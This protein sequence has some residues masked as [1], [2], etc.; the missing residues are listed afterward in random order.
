MQLSSQRSA[1]VFDIMC[2][3]SATDV[4]LTSPSANN[5]ARSRQQSWHPCNC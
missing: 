1:A 3:Y 4:D 5:S 2:A